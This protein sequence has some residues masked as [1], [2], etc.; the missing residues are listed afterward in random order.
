MDD[1]VPRFFHDLHR[2]DGDPVLTKTNGRVRFDLVDGQRTDRW[3]VTIDG[4]R[5]SAVHR[6]GPAD[7]TVRADRA[8][9]ARLSRGE[10]NAIAAVLRGALQ[11]T[12]DVELLFAIERVIPGPPTASR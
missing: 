3:S 2:R 6:G 5:L 8:W 11:V 9:F 10:E 12:G 1:D 4:G 7:C